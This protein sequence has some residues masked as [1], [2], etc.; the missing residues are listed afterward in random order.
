MKTIVQTCSSI[1][2]RPNGIVRYI[3]TVMDLQRS[4]GHHVIFVT[5]ANP[6][7]KISADE[8]IYLNNESSYVPN[9]RDGHVWLQISPSVVY[10]IEMAFRR[11]DVEPDL[12]I[13]H[14]L[15][16]FL[17]C[18]DTFRDGIFAQ[19]ESDVMNSDGRY[20][21]LSDEYLQEQIERVNTTGWRVGMCAPYSHQVNPYRPV[22]TPPPTTLE[23]YTA[24]EKTRGLLY[25]G[26]TTDRKG[27]R[28][29]M[30]MAQALGVIPTVITH[31][32]DSAVFE[33]A[34][35]HTFKLTERAEMFR[36]ISECKVAFVPSKNECF[37]LAIIECAQFIP[38]V[39]DSQYQWTEHVED[40]GVLRATG[41]ELYAVIDAQLKSTE[42]YN[43]RPLE[44]W[45]RRSRELW[46]NL[47]V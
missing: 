25:I 18:E 4:L 3:N 14:D 9:M 41:A 45:A 29:F 13:A 46:T 1:L 23:P 10:N 31:E 7:Q 33:G 30:A 35:V 21:F 44:V 43:R 42:P 38:T 28:E 36:L 16:S 8:I 6:T 20:S 27:A 15:H 34:D 17:G 24:A 11:L 26:D 5:D 40:L 12:V 22:Y 47:S 2:V 37:S 19:H 39:V 32:R